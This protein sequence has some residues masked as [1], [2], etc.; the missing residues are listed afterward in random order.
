MSKQIEIDVKTCKDVEVLKARYKVNEADIQIGK[1]VMLPGKY[2]L[3]IL[4]VLLLSSVVAFSNKEIFGGIIMLAITGGV[5]A[6]WYFLFS[7]PKLE[8]SFKANAENELIEQRLKE[9]E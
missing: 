6:L 5:Y 3:I 1:L 9:L 7:K 8:K 4:A 2:T